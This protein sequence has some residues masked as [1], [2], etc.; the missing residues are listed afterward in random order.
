MNETLSLLI[1]IISHMSGKHSSQDF[2]NSPIWNNLL[3]PVIHCWSDH[4]W[5]I[6]SIWLSTTTLCP[7]PSFSLFR[8]TY[9]YGLLQW[10]LLPSDFQLGWPVGTPSSRSEGSKRMS[11]MYLF[12]SAPSLWDHLRLTFFLNWRS[13]FHSRW[14]T[15]WLST[16]GFCYPFHPFTPF[17]LLL[18]PG[19][20][21]IPHGFCTQC[22]HLVNSPFIKLSSNYPNVRLP[23]VSY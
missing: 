2:S 10:A 19:N 18:A 9:L 13:L 1:Y 16:I 14:P 22:P 8:E 20:C 15:A 11:S 3:S 12:F 17:E 7:S 5:L 21:T 4:V 6:C 23:S